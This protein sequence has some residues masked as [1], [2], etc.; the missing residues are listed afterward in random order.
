MMR[1]LVLALLMQLGLL[2]APDPAQM[3]TAPDLGVVPAQHTLRL[4]EG[5]AMGAPSRVAMSSKGHLVV[6]TRGDR[7]LLEFDR[8]G[9][10]VRAFGDGL[11]MRAH[12]LRLDAE[13]NVWTTDVNNHT[14]IK[15]SPTGDVLLTL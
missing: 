1:V 3:E 12:G 10:F 2:S 9:A 5:M 8:T 6:F 7:P 13:D 15:M 4:P 11:Y 14:V